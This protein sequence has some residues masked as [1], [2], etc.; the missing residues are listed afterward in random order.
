MTPRSLFAGPRVW[1]I[2]GVLWLDWPS[3]Q[4]SGP[5]NSYHAE[6]LATQQANGNS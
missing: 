6:F 4:M 5:E 3:K 1:V 2:V